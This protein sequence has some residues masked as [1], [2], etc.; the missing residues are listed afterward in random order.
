MRII[1]SKDRSHAERDR[2]T[3]AS[4]S[5]LLKA[6][7]RG[8][9]LIIQPPGILGICTFGIMGH[10]THAVLCQVVMLRRRAQG[11]PARYKYIF[12]SNLYNLHAHFKYNHCCSHLCLIKIV[13]CPPNLARCFDLD[14]GHCGWRRRR[15][16]GR[17]RGRLE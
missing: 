1:V 3:C 13:S 2:K 16:P 5:K 7:I 10:T 15:W 11:P 6:K 14:H 8:G 17:R 12:A 9:K 4:S